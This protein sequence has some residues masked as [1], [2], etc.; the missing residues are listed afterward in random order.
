MN[1]SSQ[2]YVCY[3]VALEIVRH[4]LQEHAVLA[5][6]PVCVY[7]HQLLT[8]LHSTYHLHNVHLLSIH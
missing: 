7:Q 4:T 5:C 8:E 6:N 2:Q 3:V 1:K